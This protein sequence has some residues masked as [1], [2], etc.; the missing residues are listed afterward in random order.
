MR[1]WLSIAIL[2]TLAWAVSADAQSKFFEG[3]TVRIVVGFS[4]GGGYDTYSRAIAR[5]FGRHIP[6]K[7][8]VIV[9]NMP[10]AGSMIAANHLYKIAK[11]DGLTIGNFAGGLVLAQVLGQPGIEFDARKLPWLGVPSRE[12]CVCALT[13]A[14]GVTS[15]ATWMA[16]AKPVKL[17][18][19]GPG[20]STDDAPRVLAASIGLPIQLVRGYKG[21]AEIR[22]A[23]ESGEVAGGCWQ[24]ES[25]KSTWRQGLE[26]GE[27]NV[28]LQIARKPLADLP[29]VPLASSL[30][31]TDEARQ[32]ITAGVIVPTEIGRLYALPPGTPAD[33]VQALRTAWTETM[34][35]PEFVAEAKRSKLEI[36]AMD[37]DE[38]TRV[39]GELLKLDPAL[40]AK[41][42]GILK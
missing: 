28:V 13:K 16:T 22:L 11:P 26:S 12:V 40:V 21:T 8:T 32:I 38:L 23:A 1:R 19:V 37:G 17:G 33:R 3:K 18:G 2:V 34:R 24:W 35:D 36:D 6:G 14:S 4:A 7:P 20:T 27:V 41:L 10:G 29:N 25:V 30:A 5:Y 9:E 42:K 15:V 31:K 39:V